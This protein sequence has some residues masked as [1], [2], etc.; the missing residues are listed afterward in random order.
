MTEE[1]TTPETEGQ[2]KKQILPPLSIN[3]QFIKDL[4]FEAPELP[5]AL[6]G[7]KEAP[8]LDVNID[9]NANHIKENSFEVVLK[10]K[11]QAKSSENKTLFVCELAYAALAQINVPKEHAEAMLLVEVPRLLFPFARQIIADLSKETGLPPVM[12]AP[13]DFFALYRARLAHQAQAQAQAQEQ[14]PSD[15]EPSKLN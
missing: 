3:A 1:K 13:I 15:A 11:A 5:M 7:L 6:A 2:E 8:S 10:I 12:L 4:S 14:V 9:I